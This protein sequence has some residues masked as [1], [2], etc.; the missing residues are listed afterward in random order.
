MGPCRGGE[1]HPLSNPMSS[2]QPTRGAQIDVHSDTVDQDSESLES[3]TQTLL[4]SR[5][6]SH[7]STLVEGEVSRCSFDLKA[8]PSP[9]APE[10]LV[11]LEDK[12]RL[13]FRGFFPTL[14]VIA[15]TAG[16][17]TFLIGWLIVHQVPGRSILKDGAFLVYE[18]VE[19]KNGV[20]TASLWGLA[21]SSL[22]SKIAGMSGSFIMTLYGLRAAAQ[23]LAAERA[24]S[25][26]SESSSASTASTHATPTPLQYG[27]LTRLISSSGFMSLY[28]TTRY[29]WR[30]PKVRSPA[31]KFFIQTFI[32][33]IFVH[34]IMYSLTAADL[35]LHYAAGALLL[36]VEIPT[37]VD[38]SVEFNQT[39]CDTWP[40]TNFTSACLSAVDN[41]G[42][43][44]LRHTGYDTVANASDPSGL[45]VITLKD[46]GDAAVIVPAYSDPSVSFTART[47]G[48]RASCMRHNA[49]CESCQ[50]GTS[51]FGCDCHTDGYPLPYYGANAPNATYLPEN[52][53]LGLW[54]NGSVVGGLTQPWERVT[55]GSAPHNPSTILAQL[56]WVSPR[57]MID[58]D[59][60]TF[61]SYA[62]F[63][64]SCSLEIFNGTLKYTRSPLTSTLPP[65]SANVAPAEGSYELLSPTVVPSSQE[66][67]GV[68]WGASMRQLITSRLAVN[69]E[70]KA[71]T[72]DSYGDSTVALFN[73]ELARLMLGFNAGLFQRAPAT[74]ATRLNPIL[75]GR[76]PLPALLA[77]VGILY[78][79]AALAFFVFATS[80]FSSSYAIQ[81]PASLSQKQKPVLLSSLELVEAWL[82]NPL[83][84]VSALF[85]SQ[86]QHH[87]NY[88]K[89]FSAAGTM[90][91]LNM[92]VD[93][94]NTEKVLLGLGPPGSNNPRYG[95]WQR[96]SFLGAMRAS[97]VS[98]RSEHQ[99]YVD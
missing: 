33:A 19:E 87:P 23:W 47:T 15:M 42:T 4:A 25:E 92:F 53:V 3:E 51:T 81:V 79:Y 43:D 36:P 78:I 46:A 41:W 95:V 18:G 12:K 38:Y 99:E 55:N 14:V 93:T 90:E 91:S 62:S 63:L 97:G 48:I 9:S 13:G 39:W 10:T 59:G 7:R 85:P 58:P 34:S 17:G 40:R 26:G 60:G 77:Y 1:G 45:R 73:Q 89:M 65:A 31:P 32:V 27:L 84:L 56:Y 2:L 75:V 28:E 76:Y 22:V 8:P 83:T 69:M 16:L 24:D 66:Y 37:T 98:S 29:M 35:W 61:S 72:N 52:Y 6:S 88:K 20:R 68:L 11:V 50:I 5:S 82:T 96:K 54:G 57:A 74:N 21:I 49:S 80:A 71:L 94:P 44:P 30:S 70:V 64:A 67:F 86:E